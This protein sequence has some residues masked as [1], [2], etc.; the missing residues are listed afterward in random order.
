[1]NYHIGA[2]LLKTHFLSL[3]GKVS[4]LEKKIYLEDLNTLEPMNLPQQTIL[5]D[6]GL[7]VSLCFYSCNITRIWPEYLIDIPES[8]SASRN[9]NKVRFWPAYE[10]CYEAAR[11]C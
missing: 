8:M 9:H 11:S 6:N 7:P 3:Y 4:T 10:G 2:C 5:Y 1:M